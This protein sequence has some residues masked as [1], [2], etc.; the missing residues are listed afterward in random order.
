MGIYI[1]HEKPRAKVGGSRQF[2]MLKTNYG[3]LKASG[4][5][6]S[7]KMSI[8][9]VLTNLQ[10]RASPGI[11]AGAGS[12]RWDMRLVRDPR[13]SASSSIRQTR[14]AHSLYDRLV[15]FI[16]LTWVERGPLAAGGLWETQLGHRVP[17]CS[18][19][20]TFISVR[21]FSDR[22]EIYSNLWDRRKQRVTPW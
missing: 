20:A 11:D 1:E 2:R 22:G 6:M 4:S 9:P 17:D 8:N 15:P 5:S 14:T 16:R 3:D 12:C 13:I 10:H 18:C 7:L 21:E 19:H